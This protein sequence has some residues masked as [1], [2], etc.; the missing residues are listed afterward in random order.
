[1]HALLHNCLRLTVGTPD[2]N[3]RM[4]AAFHTTP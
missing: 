2:E 1:M 3:A 4:V